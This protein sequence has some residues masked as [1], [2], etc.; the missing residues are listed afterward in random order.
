MLVITEAG[1]GYLG[2]GYTV[3]PTFEILHIKSIFFFFLGHSMAYRVP[4]PEIR[5][6]LQLQ[7]KPQLQQR[8]IL[9]PLYR[10]GI[11]LASQRSQVT[12]DP[13]TPQQELL[14]N[15]FRICALCLL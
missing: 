13:V 14:K 5:F 12:T 10:P 8:Q 3:L 1:D 11:T 4:R 9:N 7:P 15:P 6:K 2:D